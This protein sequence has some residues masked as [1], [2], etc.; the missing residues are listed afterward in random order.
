MTDIDTDTVVVVGQVKAVS[1]KEGEKGPRYGIKVA[2][3]D[4]N[5]AW[6]NNFGS[7]PVNKGDVVEIEYES[8]KFGNNIEEIDIIEEADNKDDTSRG[9]NSDTGSRGEGD[10]S[11]SGV[12]SASSI[13]PSRAERIKVNVAFKE[14]V[15]TARTEGFA[16]NTEKVQVL[17]EKYRSVINEMLGNKGGN[18]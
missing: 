11:D 14:A 5:T 17:A 12:N 8:N 4:N 7:C 16:K 3:K 13:Q 9:K 10:P 1:T 2:T 15:E 6:Y 18:Q